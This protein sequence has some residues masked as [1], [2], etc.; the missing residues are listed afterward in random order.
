MLDRVLWRFVQSMKDYKLPRREL[1][2]L[3]ARRLRRTLRLAYDNVPYYHDLMRQFGKVP[4]DLDARGLKD[5]P[6]LT[7]RSVADNETQ[8][9]SRK[10]RAWQP[11]G[12]SGTSGMFSWVMYDWGFRDLSNALQARHYTMIGGRP[13]KRVVSIWSPTAYWRRSL[14]GES[15]GKPTTW[16]EEMGLMALLGRLTKRSNFLLASEDDPR[17]DLRRLLSMKPDIVM[18]RPSHLLKMSDFLPTEGRGIKVQAVECKHETFTETAKSTIEGAFGAKTFRSFGSAE[19]GF[20]AC[21]C[22]FQ[23]GIHLDEDWVLF[24]VLRD[25]ERVG[26]G[27][28]GELV[29]TVLGN[30]AMPLIRYATGDTVELSDEGRCS[31]GSSFT[32]MRRM[33]GRS[34][35]WLRTAAGTLVNPLEVA[36][37]VEGKLGMRDYQIVQRKTD[38]F[39]VK[40]RSPGPDEA[41]LAEALRGYLSEMVG[42]RVNLSFTTRPSEDTWLKNRPVVCACAKAEA[43]EGCPRG[44]TDSASWLKK[45]R[46]RLTSAP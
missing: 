36:E 27:E 10:A 28:S 21:E 22:R 3:Q 38:D 46:H 9:V 33:L 44:P 41:L 35:D 14:S 30:D 1:E 13:W 4:S 19:L 15:Q 32:L 34:E 7:R 40:T 11:R 5:F 12:G 8:L 31:C 6:V 37:F 26:P 45:A 18:G 24:E 25:G 20:A 16:S 23:T 29:A 2:S 42:T 39:V 43:A 17:Q